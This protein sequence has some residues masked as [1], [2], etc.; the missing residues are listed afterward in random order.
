MKLSIARSLVSKEARSRQNSGRYLSEAGFTLMELLIVISIM[1]IL[2]LIAIPNFA[3]MKMQ[4]NETSAIQSLRAI[5]ESQI[6]FQTTYPANGF[7]CSLQALG[8]DSKAGPPNPQ[9]AQ[10][11]QGDLAGGQKSGYTFNIVNCTKVTVNNQ[12]MYTG[13]EVTAVPQA[14]GKTGHNGFCIDQQGEVRKDATGGT[15]CTVALQ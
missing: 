6:Q 10:L 4:A 9:S 12:D 3:G 7:A 14:V 11:L 13:Y 5:Y 15:N 1:L 8:G 2:M